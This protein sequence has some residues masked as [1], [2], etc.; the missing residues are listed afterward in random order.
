M[1]LELITY[2]KK[3]RARFQKERLSRFPKH[4]PGNRIRNLRERQLL[5]RLDILRY[6]KWLKQKKLQ[7]L[8]SG[9]YKLEPGLKL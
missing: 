4:Y 8:S 5:L 2:I 9:V 3:N 7:I 6:Q 1:S